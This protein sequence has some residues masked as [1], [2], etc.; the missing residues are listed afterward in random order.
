VLI[1][2]KGYTMLTQRLPRTATEIEKIMAD[3]KKDRAKTEHG[4]SDGVKSDGGN[5]SG[6]KSSGTT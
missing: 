6:G 4:K 5:S 2:D 3:A 1:T